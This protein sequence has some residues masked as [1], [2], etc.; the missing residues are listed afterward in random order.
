MVVIAAATLA[1]LSD[2]STAK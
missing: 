2:V 1:A